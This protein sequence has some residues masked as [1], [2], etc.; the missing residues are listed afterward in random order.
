MYYVH[1]GI[2]YNNYY[3]IK[4]VWHCLLHCSSLLPY[5]CTVSAY[6]QSEGVGESTGQGVLAIFCRSAVGGG[7]GGGGGC[8]AVYMDVHSSVTSLSG[9]KD[10]RIYTTK[11]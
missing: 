9:V 11:F 7:L 10:A 3:R 1:E 4:H 5:Y 6:C 2:D 8:G